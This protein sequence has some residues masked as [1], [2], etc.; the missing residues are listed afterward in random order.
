MSGIAVE[1]L[2]SNE[3]VRELLEGMIR[4]RSLS[5]SLNKR[6]TMIFMGIQGCSNYLIAK[7]LNVDVHTVKRWRGRWSSAWP[8]ICE[9]NEQGKISRAEMIKRKIMKVLSDNRRSGA[10]RKFSM[11]QRKQ[12]IALACEKP[13]DYGVPISQWSGRALAE[14]AATKGIVESISV[15]QLHWILKKYGG[16]SSQKSILDVPQNQGMEELL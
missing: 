9:P 15:S 16:P 5:V 10:P 13:E 7:E 3:E 2:E 11:S 12:L 1:K 14:I 4:Q 8:L 6:A